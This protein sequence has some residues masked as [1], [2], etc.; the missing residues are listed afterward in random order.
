MLRSGPG[1]RLQP[2]LRPQHPGAVALQL[3]TVAYSQISVSVGVTGIIVGVVVLS[4][5]S[6]V[7]AT[8]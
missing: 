8:A 7:L 3:R 6:S 5:V 4:M 1:F 2:A